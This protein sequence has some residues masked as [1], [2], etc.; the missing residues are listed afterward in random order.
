MDPVNLKRKKSPTKQTKTN[1]TDLYKDNALYVSL[2]K[3]AISKYQ[4]GSVTD[5]SRIKMDS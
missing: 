4:E 3:T 1:V 5:S 2:V